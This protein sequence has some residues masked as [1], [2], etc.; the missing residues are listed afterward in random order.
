MKKSIPHWSGFRAKQLQDNLAFHTNKGA[1]LLVCPLCVMPLKESHIDLLPFEL[2]HKRSCYPS[3]V[4]MFRSQKGCRGKNPFY[5]QWATQFMGY[6]YGFRHNFW[7]FNSAP[8]P[9]F[10]SFNNSFTDLSNLTVLDSKPGI[11]GIETNRMQPSLSSSFH[12][13]RRDT[14]RL[15]CNQGHDRR[16]QRRLW[17]PREGSPH[18]DWCRKDTWLKHKSIRC[19]SGKGNS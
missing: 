17:E 14:N 13:S 10:I 16:K 11:G 15:C 1:H 2:N 3:L 18:A 5:L 8:S 19:N 9:S 4:C 7:D 6:Y 12:G